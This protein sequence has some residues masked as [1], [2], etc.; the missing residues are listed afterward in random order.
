MTS[1]DLTLGEAGDHLL[2]TWMESIRNKAARE[3]LLKIRNEKRQ[4]LREKMDANFYE[5]LMTAAKFR[6]SHKNYS[7]DEVTIGK[8]CDLSESQRSVLDEVLSAFKPWKKGP[9]SLFDRKID[10]EWRSE[11]KWQRFAAH[12]PGDFEGKKIADIGCNNGYFMFRMQTLRPEHVVGIEPVAKHWYLFSLLNSWAQESQ[13]HFEPLGVEHMGLCEDSFDHIFCLGILYH[14]TDPVGILRKLKKS[15]KKGGKLWID[16]QGID[17][18]LEVALVPNGR[19]AGAKGIWFLPSKSC[20]ANWIKRAGFQ[21]QRVLYSEALSP[22]EQ[23]STPWAE[24]KS[25][26]D[27]LDEKDPSKTIEGY[28]APHRFYICAW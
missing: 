4:I 13:L 5:T 17:N 2:P 28:P 8:A 20:L 3:I 11:K 25:L 23:R 18:K 10:A 27:F 12:L 21:N 26:A 15:L 9:Y 1:I 22:T 7:D 16:C 6:S 19:Y 24:I 14:H